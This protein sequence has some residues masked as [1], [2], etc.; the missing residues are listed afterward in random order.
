MALI[1]EVGD[2]A[3]AS[4]SAAQITGNPADSDG[5]FAVRISA[6]GTEPATHVGASC[7]V[8]G[9][10]SASLDA[11]KRQFKGSDFEVGEAAAVTPR[12]QFDTLLARME[13][14]DIQPVGAGP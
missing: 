8:K 5:F 12:D 3:R 13:L 14:Q 1:V 10:N 6:T 11:L 9:R 4:N 7:P 2:A